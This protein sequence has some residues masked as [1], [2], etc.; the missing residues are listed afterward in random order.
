MNYRITFLS[1]IVSGIT[2]LPMATAAMA[3]GN[4]AA[5][6]ACRDAVRRETGD[7]D[8]RVLDS[9]FSQA[10]TEVLLEAEGRRWTCLSSSD[11][12]VGSLE[13]NG[14]SYSSNR[15]DDHDDNR[16]DDRYN[17]HGNSSGITLYEDVDFR[18][19][20]DTI[21]RDVRDL[22]DTRIGEDQLSSI[23]IPPGCSVRL[24]TDDDFE[25]R[26]MTL[27]RDESNMRNTTVGNDNVESIQVDCENQ[28]SSH[29]SHGYGDGVTLYQDKAFGGSSETIYRDIPDLDRTRVGAEELSSIR[30]PSGCTVWIYDDEDYRGRSYELRQDES[31]MRHSPIGNDEAE[32]IEVECR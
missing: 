3:E 21:Y 30:V 22:D 1:T 13:P 20:S 15:Y 28:G 29:A 23:E 19:T 14:G 25:G 7:R 12:R 2:L 32:S 9:S 26:S 4:E 16:H 5:E 18:G 11:G 17:R 31:D 10:A 8:A 27:D 24:F 6:R